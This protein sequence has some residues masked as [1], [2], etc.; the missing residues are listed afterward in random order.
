MT[1]Y[2]F[3][4][5]KRLSL[6]FSFTLIFQFLFPVFPKADESPQ[7]LPKARISPIEILDILDHLSY[8]QALNK[9]C[10]F[11]NKDDKAKLYLSDRW[12]KSIT[13]R[14]G[15]PPQI[16][17]TAT[18]NKAAHLQATESLHCHAENLP[19]IFDQ[20]RSYIRKIV[21]RVRLQ[22]IQ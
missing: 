21:L 9:K 6:I 12:A 4:S 17:L 19:P 16:L 10:L 22:D 5:V 8:A 1:F 15:F 3:I 14:D 18:R 20:M 2:I 11:L 13:Y 7:D